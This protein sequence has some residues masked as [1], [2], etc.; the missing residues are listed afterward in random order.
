MHR[1]TANSDW[2]KL[3]G[4]YSQWLPM[5][6]PYGDELIS[7]SNVQPGMRVLDVACGTGEPGLTIAIK[8]PAAQVIGCDKAHAMAHAADAARRAEELF[9]LHFVVASGQR[10]PFANNRFDR[11]I[12]RF[13]LMLFDNSGA[14]LQEIFRVTKPGGTIAL[15]VWS[16]PERVL[17]PSLTL[18]VLE[19][20]TKVEWPRT[21]ALAEPG[22]LAQ[23]CVA[24]GFGSVIEETINP[25][26]IFEH[27][28]HFMAQ[29]LTGRF[30]EKPYESLSGAEQRQFKD[31]LADA[32]TEY[33]LD[34]GRIHLSQEAI[35]VAATKPDVD[36]PN[37]D[38]SGERS[39]AE[40]SSAERSSEE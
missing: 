2:E 3:A 16:E 21:F 28:D 23:M 25:G 38:E 33:T 8:Q 1:F 9:N 37:V 24:A 14:G 30:I 29:N 5:L 22:L 35:L 34:D 36:E 17:C 27:L 10:L 39:S 12:C 6:K 18:N 11:V 13:G 20:H 40:R 32:A 31:D 15:S 7:R 26:F 19:R 4:E